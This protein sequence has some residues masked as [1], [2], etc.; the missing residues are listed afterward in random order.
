VDEFNTAVFKGDIGLLIRAPGV[1]RKT[2]ERLILELKDKLKGKY[3]P[4]GTAAF[5]QTKPEAESAVMALVSLGYKQNKAREVI[6][7]IFQEEASLSVEEAVR[8]ALRLL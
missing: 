3:E 6:Q 8:K 5:T 7:R 4:T 2:A 1:G